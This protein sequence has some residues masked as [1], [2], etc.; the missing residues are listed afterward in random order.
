MACCQ[1]P[2]HRFSRRRF[3]FSA[4][5]SAAFLTEARYADAGVTGATGVR[6]RKT[7]RACIFINMAGA[8]S[9]LDTFDPKDGPWN[10]AD[11]NLTQHGPI[12]LSQGM[13]PNLSQITN[14]LC[15]LRSIKSWEAAHDRG[16]FYSQTSHPANPAFVAE[17]PNIGSVV[18]FEKGGTG[19]VPPFMALNGG[20]V[21]FQGA[22]F[23]GGLDEPFAPSIGNGSGLS[24][25]QLSGYGSNSQQRFN[26]RYNL[27]ASLD[28][29]L[30]AN[31][32]DP[33]MASHAAF[34]GAAQQLM[35]DPSIASIFQFSTDDYNRYGGTSFGSSCI[36][37]RNAIQAKNGTVFVSILLNGWDTHQNMYNRKYSPNMYS[38]NGDLDR[39]LGNLVADLKQSGD[40]SSTFIVAM[41]EFG[42]TPGV[43]NAQGGRDHH[44]DAQCALLLGGGVRGGQA[45]GATDSQ[46][47]QIIDPGWSQGRPI[48]MEDITAT[49]YSALGIDWTKTLSNTPSGR[50]FEYVPFGKEG[51]Y[52]P[53]E[54]VFG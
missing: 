23:L 27:L 44:Q 22:K 43:L 26:Q 34:Y 24:T 5:A 21:V 33:N 42:R 15:V 7:A 41:G 51:T 37:A 46:G 47:D 30:R 52:L 14:D 29:G 11:A 10:A 50:I 48:F 4:A 20:G 35:Y 1:S 16:Q 32:Y 13:F 3:L 8:P 9:Q 53:V 19:R 45:I 49:I 12:L 2:E 36:V 54:A 40:F 6:M 39:G 28:A 18:A 31:P 38:L 17:T 25:L